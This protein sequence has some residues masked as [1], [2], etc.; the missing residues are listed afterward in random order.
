MPLLAVELPCRK[1]ESA[2]GSSSLTASTSVSG[3]VA[4]LVTRCAPPLPMLLLQPRPGAP[5]LPQGQAVVTSGSRPS[6]VQKGVLELPGISTTPCGLAWKPVGA[7]ARSFQYAAG[8]FLRIA[9]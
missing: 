8:L 4:P 9:A 1:I 7:S 3:V 6:P 5:V 2:V